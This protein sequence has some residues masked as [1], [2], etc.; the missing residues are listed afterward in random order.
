MPGTYVRC[1]SKLAFWHVHVDNNRGYGGPIEHEDNA[2]SRTVAERKDRS[3]DRSMQ[4]RKNRSWQ[5]PCSQS[6]CQTSTASVPRSLPATATSGS[7]A[8]T[9]GGTC[10][11]TRL[12]SSGLII[13]PLRACASYS[14]FDPFGCSSLPLSSRPL[15]IGSTLINSAPGRPISRES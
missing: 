2:H 9:A 1:I 11:Y 7:L 10:T 12:I 3:A 4:C 5:L 13:S 6:Y 8:A 14:G 15:P